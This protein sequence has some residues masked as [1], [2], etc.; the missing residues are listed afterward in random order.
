MELINLD[1]EQNC[2]ILNTIELNTIL[3]IL[4]IFTNYMYKDS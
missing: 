1:L 3:D 2:T 4:Y